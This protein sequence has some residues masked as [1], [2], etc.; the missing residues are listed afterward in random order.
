MKKI[1]F[2]VASL[3][4]GGAQKIATYVMDIL[5]K[6]FD[7]QI[8]VISLAKS[9][10]N[11]DFSEKIKVIELNSLSKNK[12]FQKIDLIKQIKKS[13][14]NENPNFVVVFGSYFLVELALSTYFKRDFKIIGCERGD[15]KSYPIHY[16]LVNKISYRYLYD[17]TIFQTQ[18][19]RKQYNVKEGKSSVIPNPC[20][21]YN[22]E[23]AK[24]RKNEI[25]SAGR[26][27]K[28]KGFDTLLMAFSIFHK[29]H[30]DYELVIYGDGE[31]RNNLIELSKSLGIYEKVRLP[32]SVRD[33]KQYIN[34]SKIF[35]LSSWFEGIPNT[36]IEAMSIGLP[37]IAC[38]CSPGGA[39]L[40]TDSGR[41]GGPLIPIK[42]YKRMA[43]ELCK[44]IDDE[45]L[46]KYYSQSSLSV[47]ERFN[48]VKIA[49]MWGEVF[50]RI[51]A[52]DDIS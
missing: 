28:E 22:Y 18:E 21:D 19:A 16:K 27:T 5:T 37:V 17:Y 32:G 31:E 35:V 33:I 24:S 48:S 13:V 39:K 38:D 4:I 52:G 6:N 3:G 34:S 26:F 25:V 43:D 1:V 45:E 40:L 9:K 41:V 10:R 44:I 46:Y 36:L 23:I 12:I 47:R 29:T 7:V 20:Y 11:L 14:E 50:L 15:P 8:T 49:D 42:D 2:F 30:K 51:F